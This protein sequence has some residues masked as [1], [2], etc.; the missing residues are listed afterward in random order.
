MN[1]LEALIKES[2]DLVDGLFLLTVVEDDKKLLDDLQK[3]GKRMEDTSC[4]KKNRV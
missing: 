2:E 1:A 4:H 3:T